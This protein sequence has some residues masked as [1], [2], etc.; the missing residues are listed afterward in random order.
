MNSIFPFLIGLFEFALIE[1]LGPDKMELWFS[2][3]G[4]LYA[5]VTWVDHSIMRHA[6]RDGKNDVLQ[7]VR[8]GYVKRLL[9]GHR[10]RR[11]AIWR[12]FCPHVR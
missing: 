6:R 9:S 12:R 8:A 10:N 7:P 3:F 11:P 5:L 4:A 1:L 2:S